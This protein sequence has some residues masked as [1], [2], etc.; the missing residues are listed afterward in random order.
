MTLNQKHI[1]ISSIL[2]DFSFKGLSCEFSVRNLFPYFCDFSI[3]FFNPNFLLVESAWKGFKGAWKYKIAS[4]PNF[5]SRTNQKL[6]N[7]VNKAKDRGLPTVF[8]NKEDSV[9]FDRFIDSAKH[10]DHILTV[11]SNCIEKYKLLGDFKSVN[12]MMFPVQPKF[13]FFDGF[14]FKN[15]RANF[16]GSYNADIH[17]QRKYTQDW[18]LRAASETIGL[19]IYDRNS[20]RKNTMYRFPV[21]DNSVIFRSLPYRRTAHIYKSYHASININTIEDSPSMYSRR[22]IEI[23][24]CGGIAV[25][26]PSLSVETHFKDFCHVVS[27]YDEAIELFSRLKYGPS[28]KDLEK[29][30]AGADFV[31]NNHTWKHRIEDIVQIISNK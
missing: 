21:F 25:T 6:I 3:K 15:Y 26:T 7:L 24:A 8:W 27:S 1:K 12:T 14:N 28:K 19:D 16:C 30:R 9:H 29:A 31:E 18:L 13:H 20:K 10:F 22:L 4:Y 2:D 23:L 5:P 11:D 17:P